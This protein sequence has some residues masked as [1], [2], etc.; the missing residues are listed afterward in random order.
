MNCIELDVYTWEGMS[1][2][3]TH[4]YGDLRQLYGDKRKSYTEIKH[5]L[6][7]KDAASINKKMRD[8]I[9]EFGDYMAVQ[10][11]EMDYRYDTK[12]DVIDTAKLIWKELYPDADR[13]ILKKTG[14]VLD[15]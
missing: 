5:K 3:A 14:E 6:S 15:E 1:L 8:I 11:G 13:L 9:E 12:E 10:P 2:G 4:Y 7:A